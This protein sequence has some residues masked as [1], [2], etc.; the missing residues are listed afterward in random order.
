[1]VPDDPNAPPMTPEQIAA[2]RAARAAEVP[3][4]AATGFGG[5]GGG[6]GF[7]F[8][9]PQGPLLPPGSYM[10]RLTAGGQTLTT[11]V[12]LLDDVWLNAEH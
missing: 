11:S 3:F 12:D 6:G 8:G 4:V 1:M 7:G 10:V 5:G 9:T 2:A